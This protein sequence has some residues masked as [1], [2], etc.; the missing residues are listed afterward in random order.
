MRFIEQLTLLKN[1]IKVYCPALLAD[2]SLISESIEEVSQKFQ[3]MLW[4]LGDGK[5]FEDIRENCNM[6]DQNMELARMDLIKLGLIEKDETSESGYILTSLGYEKYKH[7]SFEKTNEKIPVIINTVTGEITLQCEE[8]ISTKD[9][10]NKDIPILKNKVI[11]H[12]LSNKNVLNS[13]D[14]AL[15]HYDF[16]KFTDLEI[17]KMDAELKN[18]EEGYYIERVIEAVPLINRESLFS[19]T[20]EQISEG[21]ASPGFSLSLKKR[22]YDFEKDFS[23]DLGM[24]LISLEIYFAYKELEPY[25]RGMSD[26]IKLSEYAPELLSDKALRLVE[27]HKKEL[28]VKRSLED[29]LIDGITGKIFKAEGRPLSSTNYQKRQN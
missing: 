26:L 2:L 24:P 16:S 5:D 9:R 1:P 12:T 21:E 29:L 13:R 17:N 27:L 14:I 20:E 23:L 28:K 3:F 19:L 18:I 7:I 10:L 6:K 4:Q 22:L 8:D 15:K 25:K 11:V